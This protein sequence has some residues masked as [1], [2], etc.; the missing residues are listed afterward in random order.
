VASSDLLNFLS[1]L[2]AVARDAAGFA[3]AFFWAVALF[4]AVALFWAVALF[5]V[6]AV[7]LSAAFTL[8]F[9]PT[10]LALLP[11]LPALLPTLPALLPLGAD[12]PGDFRFPDADPVL[13]SMKNTS[14]SFCF[15]VYPK[16]GRLDYNEHIATTRYAGNS[17]LIDF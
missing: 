5:R 11:T 2:S 17:I 6:A 1:L 12:F 7:F 10:L 14:L 8:P 9:L 13:G 15:R 3:V 16:A 4:R